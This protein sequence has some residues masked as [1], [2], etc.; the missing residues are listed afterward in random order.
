MSSSTKLAATDSRKGMIDYW[1]NRL[2]GCSPSLYPRVDVGEWLSSPPLDGGPCEFNCEV[3]T[4]PACKNAYDETVI[5]CA[6]WSLLLEN[7]TAV[8]DTCFGL[9]TQ[10]A[11]DV[12]K[13]V[14]YP[15]RITIP[16]NI[17]LGKFLELTQKMIQEDRV[18]S[19]INIQRIGSV[20]SGCH[21]RY[22]T[23]NFL[24]VLQK[25]ESG[26]EFEPCALRLQCL[27]HDDSLELR[28]VYNA[29]CL[30]EEEIKRLLLHLKNVREKVIFVRLKRKC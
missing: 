6:A 15:F 1:K 3:I 7:Y 13:R 14:V 4:L 21:E 20:E 28:A 11:D 18:H 16:E 29:Q 23:R 25:G 19:Y 22:Y 5:L 27:V 2:A 10:S 9:A 17:T 26:T 12:Y 24:E 30:G 8:H